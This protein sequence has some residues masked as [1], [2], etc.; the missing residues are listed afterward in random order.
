[1]TKEFASGITSFGQP[2][3]PATG[4]FYRGVD[5]AK[6][7][8][9]IVSPPPP[10]AYQ[11]LRVGPELDIQYESL[12]ATQVELSKGLARVLSPFIIQVEPPLVFGGVG[13]FPGGQTGIQS[14]TAYGSA[15]GASS[16]YQSARANL[17]K[18][19]IGSL[20]YTAGSPEALV[21]SNSRA[22]GK[23]GFPGKASVSN[24]GNLGAP[25]IADVYAAVDIAMQLSA[26]L[27]TPPLVLLINP[28][29]LTVDRTK[30]QQYQDRTRYGYVFQAWGEEQ[31]KLSITAK[32]GAFVSGGRGVHMA[33]K[34][35][36]LAW[37]NL[38]NAF[39]FYRNNGYIYDTVGKSNAHHFVGALSIQYDQ[40]I[41]YGHMESFSFTMEDTSQQGG[42]EFS[43]EFTVSRMLDTAPQ[44]FTVLPMKSPTPSLSDPRYSGMGSR[45]KNQAGNFSIGPNGLTTQG[46]QIG[47][48]EAGMTL[49]PEN[50][51]QVFDP[52][53]TTP[54]A[55]KIGTANGIPTDPVES[56][57]FQP[58]TDNVPTP[59]QRQVNLANPNFVKSFTQG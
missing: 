1:M 39:H 48:S 57:G 23:E 12:Q 4:A 33:S 41:Y 50:G 47:V 55:T 35:D 17:S 29:S 27:N 46:R 49:L 19:G 24:H 5:P 8:A 14:V 10:R 59:G 2:V 40:W 22:T 53:F 52:N 15:Q 36:S 44:P 20:G 34:R 3:P 18:S 45:S 28:T 9:A 38:M 16:G 11:G 21:T 7:Q 54:S 42:I 26:Q 43:M 32:C 13:G 25:A 58:F 31:P 30:L 6:K 51:V 56:Q 37:Q